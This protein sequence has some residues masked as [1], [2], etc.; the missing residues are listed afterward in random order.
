[1][2]ELIKIFVDWIKKKV[3]L[4]TLTKGPYFKEGEIW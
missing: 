2:Q 3:K 4:H 1:M